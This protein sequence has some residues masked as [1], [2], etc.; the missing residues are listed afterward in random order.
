M[1]ILFTFAIVLLVFEVTNEM[2]L[3]LEETVSTLQEGMKIPEL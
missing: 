1:L 2:V 3:P